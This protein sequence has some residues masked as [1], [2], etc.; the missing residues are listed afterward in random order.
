MKIESIKTL[1]KTAFLHFKET[2]Y[3]DRDGKLKKWTWVGRPGARRAVVIV[4]TTE[5]NKLV[6]TKEFRVPLGGV[7]HGFPAGLI[8]IGETPTEAATRELKEETGLDVERITSVSPPIYSSA[9]LTNE[10]VFIVR[11]VV[12]GEISSDGHESSEDITTELMGY[13]MLDAL[14]SSGKMIGAKAYICIEQFMEN[15]YRKTHEHL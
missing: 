1:L 4:A 9:G 14:L 13:H 7:E 6:I 2:T 15:C 11:C 3:T 8:D 12:S 10:S 5:D